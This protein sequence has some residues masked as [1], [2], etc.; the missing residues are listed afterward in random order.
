VKKTSF[1]VLFMSLALLGFALPASAQWVVVDPTNLVQNIMTAANSIK[2]V[3]NQVQ[4]LAN[5]AQMLSSE[6]KNLESL[7][8]NSL[9]SL[10]S[11]LN[12]TQRLLTQTQGIALQLSQT[13]SV[14]TRAYPATYGAS[15][16]HAQLDAD[17]LERWTDSHGALGTT[18]SVQAQAAQNFPA[19]Q[20][21]LSNLVG[22]SQ[23][24]AGALQATQV[25]NQI[26]AL[27]IRLLMQGQQLKITQDRAVALEQAR[28]VETDPR[29]IQ[30][31]QRFM[32]S[33]TNYTPQA[34]NGF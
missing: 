12:N 9:P 7:K 22:Q 17:A 20:T 21:T 18:L 15:V 13:Q 30:L 10:L 26:L 28:A 16:S 5:E 2:Q 25:T 33:T 34:L 23:A 11:A 27:Q 14:Y 32:S 4:Q 3:A 1:L 8:F 31:R 19:D 29:S 6:G 24:A